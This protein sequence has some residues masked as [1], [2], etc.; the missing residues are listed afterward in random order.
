MEC[1][2]LYVEGATFAVN[3][4]NELKP[5]RVAIINAENWIKDNADSLKMLGIPVNVERTIVE[6]DESSCQD[7]S[8][9][10]GMAV[11]GAGA[12][13]VQV[14]TDDVADIVE[15]GNS[16]ENFVSYG[17]LQRLC[18]AGESVVLDSEEL[19][20]AMER[21]LDVDHWILKMKEVCT[22]EDTLMVGKR[23]QG[24]GPSSGYVNGSGNG[25]GYRKK[26][27]AV[28]RREDLVALIEEA[29][30]LRVNLSSQKKTVQ[31]RTSK[32]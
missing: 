8:Q 17:V 23:N 11:D 18:V 12:V 2:K 30:S 5:F 22:A 29:D 15:N 7:E 32:V 1:R 25:N 21:R 28:V 26:A 4:Q 20:M 19:S 9:G 24:G 31:V 14:K 10:N 3:F 13:E 6:D 16:L 27:K